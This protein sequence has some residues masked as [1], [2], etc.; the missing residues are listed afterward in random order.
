VHAPTPAN[1]VVGW[2]TPVPCQTKPATYAAELSAVGTQKPNLASPVNGKFHKAVT[3]TDTLA[4]GSQGKMYWCVYLI[5]STTH[6]TFKAA[7]Y[8]YSLLGAGPG[9]P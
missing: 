5:N 6:K 4:T 7:F 3:V 1:E 8:T 2:N 9:G